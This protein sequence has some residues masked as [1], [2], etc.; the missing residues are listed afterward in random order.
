MSETDTDLA[1]RLIDAAKAAGAEAA[2]ALV[3]SETALQVGVRAGVLEEAEREES[4]GLGLRVLI[5]QRQ[6]CVASSTAA[7]IDEM[8][9]RAV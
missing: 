8:A 2:D 4:T 7:A 1:A 6:A 3:I 5:G 9:A